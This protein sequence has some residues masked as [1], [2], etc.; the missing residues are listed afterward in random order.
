MRGRSTELESHATRLE[1]GL[2]GPLTVTR[3]G[4]PVPLNAEK[5]RLLMAILLLN[6]NR[7]VGTEQLIDAV[8]D[9]EPP[10]TA[11]KG[12]QVLVSRLR[13]D[14]PGLASALMTQGRGYRLEVARDQID[15]ERFRS[16]A[17]AGR[18][19]LAEGNAT[20][21]EVRLAAAL[22]LWRGPALADLTASRH[23]KA[24][25]DR[26]EEERLATLEDSID[27]RLALG[28]HAELVGELKG[29]IER[30]PFRE[31]LRGQLMLALYRSGRQAESLDAYREA[32]LRLAEELGLEPG[33]LLRHLE[34]AILERDPNLELPVV[35]RSSRT[36]PLA[37]PP[38][39]HRWPRRAVVL[40]AAA[41]T[42]VA[43]TIAAILFT[44]DSGAGGSG[45]VPA[46][47]AAVPAA[48]T[49]VALDPQTG[50]VTSVAK[51]GRAPDQVVV[52]RGAA[53]VVDVKDKSVTRVDADSGATQTVSGFRPDIG[54]IAAAPI[55][56]VFVSGLRHSVW[57]IDPK[58]GDKQEVAQLPGP[59][60]GIAA[61]AGSLWVTSPSDTRDGGG[62]IVTQ[63]DPVTGRVEQRYPVGA[64]P[65]FASFGYGALWVSDY[66]SDMV[67][68]V[69]PGTSKVATIPVGHGP[70][71][72]ASG[73]GAIWVVCY[74]EQQL[75]RIDPASRQVVAQIPVGHGPLSV[76]AGL[77]S[78]W[79]TNRRDGTVTR[80][81]PTSNS[82]V[83]TIKV[84]PSPTGI[85]VGENRVWVAVAPPSRF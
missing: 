85:A 70:L 14:V 34:Q 76:A 36:P 35:D 8:W 51:I 37:G 77:G 18:R 59:T 57:H 21:A 13:Q 19:S 43:G 65:L 38:P 58:T 63:L 73:E 45:T 46:S 80:I 40:A 9:E 17:D 69:Y 30:H 5:Q 52:A 72:I 41:G 28:R 11:A 62:D 15:L 47:A 78:V 32:R 24:A 48:D 6:A 44:S 54:T 2:L 56:D 67:S 50:A 3:G 20:Q 75:W 16:L 83:S 22:D 71:G 61:G 64:T 12:L 27:A 26:L 66:D 1:F 25:A 82:V 81:D 29:E 49:L 84:K 33:P 10:P 39:S 55:G 31:Q 4:M 42:V 23:A 74:G 53:W 68:V 60:Q 7:L 79:V